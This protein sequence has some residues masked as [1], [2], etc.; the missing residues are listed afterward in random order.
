MFANAME[1]LVLIKE[2]AERLREVI[3]VNAVKVSL[4]VIVRVKSTNVIASHVIIME[5]VLIKWL[6]IAVNVNKDLLVL[7]VRHKLMNV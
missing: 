5:L 3:H 2:L 4:G 6:V 1:H 7:F